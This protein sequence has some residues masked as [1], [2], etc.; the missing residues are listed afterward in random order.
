[1]KNYYLCPFC[2]T[3]LKIKDN[4]ILK[5]SNTKSQV[6]LVLLSPEIGNYDVFYHHECLE[7][8]SG[9]ITEIFCPVCDENLDLDAEFK[10]LAK[11]IMLDENGQKSEVFFSRIVGEKAS[12]KISGKK[13]DKYGKDS[14]NYNYWG[15]SL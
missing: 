5:V 2:K 9:E 8:N 4:I 12:Y 10:N 11:I 14:D 1:M 3:H 13:I 15:Y 7:L 6:G